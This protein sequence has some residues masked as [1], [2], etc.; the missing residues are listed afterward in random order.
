MDAVERGA[1]VRDI[2]IVTLLLNIGLRRQELCALT[3]ARCR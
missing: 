2:A 3:S 1:Q